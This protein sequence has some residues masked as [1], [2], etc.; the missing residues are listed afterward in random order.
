MTQPPPKRRS[1]LKIVLIVL[2]VLLVTCCAVA[3]P[4]GIYVVNKANDAIGPVRESANEFLGDIQAARYTSAY[5]R[6]C[7]DARSDLSV[8]DFERGASAR[9]LT[10]YEIVG[11]HVSNVNGRVTGTVTARLTYEAFNEQHVIPMVSEDGA[12]KVCGRP[13]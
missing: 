10:G 11:V 12:W 3:I 4:T 2:G 9:R 5:G 7:T 1:Q 6:L 13:Y 8:A